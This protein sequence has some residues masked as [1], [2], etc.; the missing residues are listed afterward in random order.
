MRVLS[1]VHQRAAGPG[2][3][4]D[5]V[6]RRGDDLEEWIPAEAAPPVLDGYGAALVFGGAM[7]ADHE[8]ANPWLRPEKDLLRSL[9]ER[10]I[11]V[12]GVC[13]GSQLLAEAAGGEARPA[14]RPEMGWHDVELDP[15][16]AS[17]PLLAP[18][19]RRLRAFE[20]HSYEFTLPPGAVP[21]ARSPV[22]TQAYRLEGDRMS[23]SHGGPSWGI[24]FHAEAT[25][26]VVDRWLDDH[27][28]D[29]HAVRTGIDPELIRAETE[30]R[31]G[32]WNELGRG[33]C[34]RFLEL[35]DARDGS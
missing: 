4:A 17:D 29:G 15:R 22:C 32:A 6:D 35:G 10:G 31:I 28:E 33:I 27:R 16:A 1:I 19:P 3:F 21:L 20:W 8:D 13:L 14:P 30:D 9:L 18:L 11:P 24:Q 23:A 2:V 25:A 5:A 26:E 12:L 7:H 34:S